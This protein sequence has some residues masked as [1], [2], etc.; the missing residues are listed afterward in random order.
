MRFQSFYFQAPKSPRTD[1]GPVTSSSV[2]YKHY[3]D[4]SSSS[5]YIEHAQSNGKKILNNVVTFMESG[6]INNNSEIQCNTDL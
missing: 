1:N 2:T 4:I 5:P 6:I 3:K